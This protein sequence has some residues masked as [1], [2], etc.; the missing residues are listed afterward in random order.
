MKEVMPAEDHAEYIRLTKKTGDER[1]AIRDRM[2]VTFKFALDSMM[3]SRWIKAKET[4]RD[5]ERYVVK[6]VRLTA[7]IILQFI[8][9]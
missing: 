6:R 4:I 3:R 1:S 5:N 2:N 7:F 9:G 8:P